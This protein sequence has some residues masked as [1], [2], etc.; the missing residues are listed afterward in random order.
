MEFRN[1]YTACNFCDDKL[2]AAKSGKKKNWNARVEKKYRKTPFIDIME[3]IGI[4]FSQRAWG[5]YRRVQEETLLSKTPLFSK[6]FC[7]AIQEG[8]SMRDIYI[9]RK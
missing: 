1:R 2:I 8:R 5:K 4:F 9:R 3:K 7:F 6:G